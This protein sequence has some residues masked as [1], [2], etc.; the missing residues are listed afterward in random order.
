MS[1]NNTLHKMRTGFIIPNNLIKIMEESKCDNSLLTYL[2]GNE[3]HIYYR[4]GKILGLRHNAKSISL[5]FDKK[6]LEINDHRLAAE[7]EWLNDLK[8]N[9]KLLENNPKVFFNAAKKVMDSWF[10][11]HKKQERDD[12]HKIALRNDTIETEKD[13]AVI[14]IEYAVSANSPCYNKFYKDTFGNYTKRYPNP[15]FDIVAIS[16]SG[17]IYVLELKT[18]LNSTKN[19]ETHISD[20][21]AMIGSHRKDSSGVPRYKTFLNEMSTM[22]NVLNTT[23]LRNDSDPFPKVD[24]SKPPIFGFIYTVEDDPKCKGHT[25]EYQRKRIQEIVSSAIDKAINSSSRRILNDDVKKMIDE[26]F[27]L[28][29]VMLVSKNF[30]LS[31]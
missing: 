19:S 22:I 16:G 28:K 18:G 25:P 27:V 15:R 1:T 23:R 6:Y 11:M 12:Q 8:N 3:I 10:T 20:F 2:R 14:D 4:G 9:R 5:D 31:L 30:K 29:Q 21:V 24:M 26:G 17:Q 7:Y 13:L